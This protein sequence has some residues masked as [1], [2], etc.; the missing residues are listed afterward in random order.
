MRRKLRT[1][2]V[3]AVMLSGP[4]AAQDAPFELVE[5]GIGEVTDAIE[6]GEASAR[7]VTEM[8]L[9]RVAAFDKQGP[10][11]NAMITVNPNAL[12]RADE[13]DRH[14]EQLGLVGPLHGVPVIVKDNYDTADMATSA[15]SLALA[16]SLP[17]DD[18]WQVRKLR[19]AGA[20]II[21]KSNMAE[22]AFSPFHTVGSALPGH[23]LNPYALN[24]V[25]AGS[26]G[27]TAA[28]VA[29]S[30]G[31]VGLGTDTGN[32]I[33]GPSSHTALVGIRSTLG[34]TSRDGIVPLYLDHDVG[35]PMAK[36]VRD[37][38]IVLTLIAGRD[39]ADPVTAEAVDHGDYTRY[40]DADGLRGARL[41][42]LRQLSNRK[43]ADARVL[44]LFEAALEDLEGGGATVVDELRIAELDGLVP[45]VE[46]EELTVWCPRFRADFEDYLASLGDAAPYTSISAI[47]ESG[48][49]H[50]TL[51]APLEIDKDEPPPG[52]N[53]ECAAAEAGRDQLRRAVVALLEQHNLDAL[54]YPSWSNV[55]RL[56]GDMNTPHGDNSQHVSPHTGFPAVTVPM[57][58]VDGRLPAGLQMVA[59]AYKEPVLLRLAYAY[60]QR[61]QHRKAPEVTPPLR[62]VR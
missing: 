33:R 16:Q 29:A 3:L 32:S 34:Q 50:P 8:A 31:V 17:P 43:G 5:A 47:V 12:E 24:R 42:V 27:G 14:F 36:S 30:F 41:G 15:G 46:G 1:T 25:P 55:P 51:R 4:A 21:G 48:D 6:A 52:D 57:G 28:A 13:L 39:P 54:V 18:A 40:L 9:A 35:G 2:A 20:V 10:S 61:T 23:T 60:E 53:P 58:Y 7:E 11:I 22:F 38:A 45:P 56:I 62:A 49:F 26:S 37:A 59:N 44:D 19:E